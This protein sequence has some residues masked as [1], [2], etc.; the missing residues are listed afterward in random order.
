MTRRTAV[1]PGAVAIALVA[2]ACGGASGLNPQAINADASSVLQNDVLALSRAVAAHNWPDARA[3]LESLRADLDASR[4]TGSIG[5]Q[6][7][8]AI[9]AVLNQLTASMPRVSDVTV[10]P[11]FTPPATK[12]ASHPAPQPAPPAHHKHHGDG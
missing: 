6:R 7:A 1:L 10:Q 2:T 8:D 3:D 4:S 5:P 9:S 11:T 12:T